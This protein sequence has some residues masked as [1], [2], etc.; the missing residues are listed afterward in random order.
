[1]KR[2]V[3]AFF[4]AIVFIVGLWSVAVTDDMLRDFMENSLGQYNIRTEVEGLRK[5]LLF[6]FKARLI[7][8]YKSDKKLLVIDN[9]SAKIKPFAL[10]TRD[11]ALKFSGTVGRGVIEGVLSVSKGISAHVSVKEA[12]IESMPFLELTGIGGRGKLAGEFNLEKKSGDIKFNLSGA[13]LRTSSFGGVTVPLDF[14]ES[15]MGAMRISGDTLQIVSFSME[16]RSIYARIKGEIAGKNMRATLELMPEQSFEKDNIIL[17]ALT[18]Y[19]VS[20]GYY[21]IPISKTFEF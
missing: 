13:R 21:S 8:V 18:A 12:D 19:R 14:F 5:G 4:F 10:I 17:S 2:L 11:P 3:I 1:M 15:A 6:N 20:P 16:G 7:T 9:V